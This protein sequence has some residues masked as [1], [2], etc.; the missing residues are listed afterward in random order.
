MNS[1]IHAPSMAFAGYVSDTNF[2]FGRVYGLMEVARVVISSG[3][4]HPV[5]MLEKK[6]VQPAYAWFLAL[7]ELK[8]A[9]IHVSIRGTFVSD[10]IAS[11]LIA[12][13]IIWYV[14]HPGV[15]NVAN[16]YE[17]KLRTGQIEFPSD[18]IIFPIMRELKP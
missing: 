15:R 8:H 9:S 5:W 13:H 11:Y 2:K 12:N 18:D 6:T 7:R 1:D 10:E 17:A 16:V 14:A 3:S 4:P